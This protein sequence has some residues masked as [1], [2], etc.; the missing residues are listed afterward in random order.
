[1][2]GQ[3][4]GVFNGKAGVLQSQ[5]GKGIMKYSILISGIYYEI[6]SA[7]KLCGVNKFPSFCSYRTFCLQ[8]KAGR[9]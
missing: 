1:M 6:R 5:N 3:N 2:Y 4:S 8:C 9:K 7:N